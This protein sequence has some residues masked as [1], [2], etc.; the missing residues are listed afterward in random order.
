MRAL[1]T[2]LDS[3]RFHVF[4]RASALVLQNVAD[5]VRRSTARTTTFPHRSG[6][7]SW[8]SA[9]IADN[10]MMVAVA[11]PRPRSTGSAARMSISVVLVASGPGTLGGGRIRRP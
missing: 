6:P 3:Q 4:G 9:R 7:L 8:I 10:N 11:T 1:L 2:T 5:P